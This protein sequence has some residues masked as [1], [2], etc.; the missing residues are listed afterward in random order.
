MGIAAFGRHD[1][2]HA[3]CNMPCRSSAPLAT[4]CRGRRV[5][6]D[7]RRA[8]A[9]RRSHARSRGTVF[10]RCTAGGVSRAGSSRRARPSTSARDRFASAARARPADAAGRLQSLL[11]ERVRDVAGCFST[12]FISVLSLPTIV[13][14]RAGRRIERVPDVGVDVGMPAASAS[15]GTSGVALARCRTAGGEHVELARL[16]RSGSATWTGRNI[17]LIWPPSKSGTA[18]AVPL[19]G[20][21]TTS[22][23]VVDLNS[24]IAR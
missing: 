18:P 3:H 22:M 14:R 7:A 11:G 8:D 12:R 9:G 2:R 23:P 6:R 10:P 19:Y 1:D 16:A 13:A 5:R 4:R 17:T 21:C 15:D 20:T 24:S